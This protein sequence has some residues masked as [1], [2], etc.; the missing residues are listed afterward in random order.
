MG[1]LVRFFRDQNSQ[2]RYHSFSRSVDGSIVTLCGQGATGRQEEIVSA[3]YRRRIEAMGQMCRL[4]VH[5]EKLIAGRRTPP[6][7]RGRVKPASPAP[8]FLPTDPEV[9]L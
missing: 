4:C 6:P 1:E 8:P 9:T 2:R 5:Q 7:R 3:S